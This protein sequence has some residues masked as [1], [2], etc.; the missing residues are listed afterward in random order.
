VENKNLNDLFGTTMWLKEWL[1]QFCHSI[2]SLKLIY[3]MLR[4]CL[5]SLIFEV[6]AYVLQAHLTKKYVF[7]NRHFLTSL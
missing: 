5:A 2:L 3:N 4:V 1:I 6:I 7:C